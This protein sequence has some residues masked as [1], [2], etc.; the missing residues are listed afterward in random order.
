MKKTF[1]VLILLTLVFS[2]SACT[3]TTQKTPKL[4][5]KTDQVQAIEIYKP[6]HAYSEGDVNLFRQENTP[7]FVLESEANSAFL[8]ELVALKFEEET[9]FLPIPM[10]GGSDYE[11]YIVAV[12]YSDGGYDIIAEKGLYFYS[13]GKNGEGK[14]KYDPSDYCGETPW[15]DFI[16]K[17][18]RK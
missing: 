15:E 3:V 5:Q 2:L 11:G 12:V 14:H 6:D 16:E 8:D 9:V 17:Y 18:I 7:V 10:D 4:S 1:S 13:V